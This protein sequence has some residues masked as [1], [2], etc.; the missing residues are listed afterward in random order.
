MLGARYFVALDST[1]GAR[2]AHDTSV[3]LIF[4]ALEMTLTRC[5]STSNYILDFNEAEAAEAGTEGDL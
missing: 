1:L 4:L 2:Q 3:H 5:A